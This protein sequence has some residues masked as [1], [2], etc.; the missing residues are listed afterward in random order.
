[1]KKHVLF[2]GLLAVGN[3][4]GQTFS[5][6][7]DSY[8]AG[9]YLCPQS[10][11]A[12]TTWSN[13]PGTAEDVMVSSADASS[14]S[15][16]LY[17]STTAQN[18]GPTDLVKNFGVLNTGQFSMSFNIKVENGKAGYFNFQK[19][20][21]IG[22]VWAMD[23]FFADNGSLVINNQSGLNFQS[24][25]PQGQ[26]FN[27]RIDIDFNANVWE[28]F[29]NNVS[30]G[31][32]ANTENQI[33]SIDIYPTDQNTPYSCGYYIDD[34][35]YTITPYTLPALNAAAN[36]VTYSEGNLTGTAV[37]PKVTV[38]NLGTTPITSVGVS[39]TYNGNTISN[40]FTGLN[41]A[42]LASTTVT[43]PN[44][45]TLAAGTLPMTASI[46]S[47][48]GTSPDNDAADDDVTVS[49]TPITPAT[50]RMVVGE[51]G[52]GTWC[53]WCPRGAVFMDRM[54]T[55][56]PDH[57]AGIAVHNGDP[58]VVTDYDAAIGQLIAGYPSALVDRGTDMDP[59]EMEVEFLNRVTIAPTAYI[60]NGAT[61]DAGTRT[62][63]VSVSAL[64]QMP[65]DNNYKLAV[66]LTEDGV[67][68]TTSGYNQANY[69]ANN[70]A[71]PMGGFEALANPVPAATMVYD[72]VA[73]AI[74]P[75]FAGTNA[76][77]PATVLAGMTHTLNAS[78]V[79]PATWDE[80]E[81]HI[82]GMLID[83]NG[84]IDNAGK[85]TIAEAV[86]NGWVNSISES[87]AVNLDNAVTIYPNPAND[88]AVVSL[89]LTGSNEVAIRLMDISGKELTAKSYGKLSGA[90]EF[91]VYTS[92]YAPGIY[93]VEVTVDG[94]SSLQRLVIE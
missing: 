3:A 82:I 18:G 76:A 90:L 62:L 38:R 91:P 70:A 48:N 27:F 66:V 89:N 9:Q 64:F 81:I 92:N 19:N 67:T 12:W 85:A 31:T 84:N 56:Y 37:T 86:A 14:P 20:A 43:M 93:L 26:W 94:V 34:F 16:S 60:T 29:I 21:T 23:C 69:Y 87:E 74:A 15:N 52:T 50:G 61:W 65:A 46:T 11:G 1:M 68:G 79:L 80:N 83:P 72:H 53:G 55:K 40:T 33:A 51:E 78:F 75:S 49:I 58:M 28:V 10:G 22:Q 32:F 73:R 4:F 35:Q 39:V 17:F 59:S 25:Y 6:N 13:A 71:G 77:F 47:V 30:A 41:L 5:D 2:L 63:N 45:L 54:E 88:L 8:N 7:F 36:N 24:T 42:S 44:T 57:W